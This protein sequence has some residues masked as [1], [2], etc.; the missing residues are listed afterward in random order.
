[1]DGYSLVKAVEKLLQNDESML[2]FFN[3]MIQNN[4][5]NGK[6]TNIPHI[7]TNRNIYSVY[8]CNLRPIYTFSEPLNKKYLLFLSNVGQ[9]LSL[10]ATNGNTGNFYH[11]QRNIESLLRAI[12]GSYQ[13][14][15]W[16]QLDGFFG[17]YLNEH[18][19]EFSDIPPV[20][21]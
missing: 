8:D 1:M 3:P 4:S 10:Y 9:R 14:G 16:K 21:K 6:S 11:N 5:P 7:I 2:V 18:T 12:P 13:N 17:M 20:L 15:N 19:M